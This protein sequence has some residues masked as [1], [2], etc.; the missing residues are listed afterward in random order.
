MFVSTTNNNMATYTKL[1]PVI[2]ATSFKHAGYNFIAD[3]RYMPINRIVKDDEAYFLILTDNGQL[4]EV[5]TYY[6]LV[7]NKEFKIVYQ[8]KT[9]Q[10][11]AAERK[12]Q[13]FAI[14]AGALEKYVGAHNAIRAIERALN[15]GETKYRVQL[16]ACGIIDFYSK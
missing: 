1:N 15:S 8:P 9:E 11:G 14:G 10:P 3:Q 5:P 2:A 4:V 13:R 6:F 12:R 7:L 16:R